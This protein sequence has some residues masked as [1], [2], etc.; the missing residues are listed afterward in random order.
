MAE[1]WVMQS[2]QPGEPWTCHAMQL[3]LCWFTMLALRF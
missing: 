3:H 1:L 2:W